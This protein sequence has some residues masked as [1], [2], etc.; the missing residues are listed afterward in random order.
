MTRDSKLERG[1]LV[2]SPV[3]LRYA[4]GSVYSL[5]ASYFTLSLQEASYYQTSEYSIGMRVVFTLTSSTKLLSLAAVQRFIVKWR[6][7]AGI[8]SYQYVTLGESTRRFKSGTANS[9]QLVLQFGLPAMRKTPEQ[10]AVSAD[11]FQIGRVGYREG[12]E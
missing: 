5:R 11:L 3:V 12:L 10:L 6:D 7:A 2:S 4:D 1:R 8:E 9:T